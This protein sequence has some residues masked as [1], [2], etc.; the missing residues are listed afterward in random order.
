MRFTLLLA[1]VIAIAAAPVAADVAERTDSWTTLA[2]PDAHAKLGRV[3]YVKY[4]PHSAQIT[5]T[6]DAPLERIVGTSNAVVGYLVAE[7][8]NDEPTGKI[9]AGAFRVPVTSFDTGIPLRDE[10]LRGPY[11]LNAA[12]HPEIMVEVT[13]S[14]S[15]AA[16]AKD[17]KSA[18]YDVKL[19]GALTMR[20]VTKRTRFPHAS[21]FSSVRKRPSPR[22]R[23]MCSP[24]VVRT[25]SNARTSR[26]QPGSKRSS[27]RKRFRSTSS[28]S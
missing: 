26:L 21:P 24:C 20:G 13:G 16:G 5:F 3:Y 23:A 28:S 10:H 27:S 8:A 1:L 25:K 6:S 14:T 4:P 18:T 11:F 12:Q 22:D 19:A 17:E 9:L 2:V 7:V 15:V